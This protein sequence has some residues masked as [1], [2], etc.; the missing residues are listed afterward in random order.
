NIEVAG[1][2][3]CPKKF[4]ARV[5]IWDDDSPQLPDALGGVRPFQNSN[6]NQLSA[7]HEVS[8]KLDGTLSELMFWDDEVEPVMTI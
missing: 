6:Y 5:N 3:T 8:F 4:K 7:R 2:L 1:H